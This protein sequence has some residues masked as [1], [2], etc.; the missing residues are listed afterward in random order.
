MPI[1]IE[2]ALR[3]GVNRTVARNGL[4]LVGVLFVV[5]TV[6]TIVGLG[7]TRWV[8]DRGVLPPEF[9]FPGEIGAA[10]LAVP[11]VVGGLV[12]LLAG[13]ATIVLTI[14]A[15]R[16]FVSDET[17]RLPGANFTQNIVWP[18]VNFFVGVIVFAI[19]VGIGFVLFVIPGIFLLVALAFWTVYVATEDR[20][21]I[22]GMQESWALTRGHRLRL[23]LLGVAVVL[24][25][26]VVSA[27]F[28]IGGVAGGVVGVVIT[29][30][31]SA[32]T[33]VFTLATLAAAFN[34]L[35]ALPSEEETVPADSETPAPV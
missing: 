33:T 13:L 34:Q 17:E 6:N 35:I 31:G 2:A 15:L 14:G 21:F 27:V 30:V 16:T 12:S 11:P 3:R 29:Q 18:G 22:A 32:L 8:A 24:I 28:G 19:I 25:E 20:N 1:N 23:F 5:S 26:L 9:P 7:V 10:P 4:L